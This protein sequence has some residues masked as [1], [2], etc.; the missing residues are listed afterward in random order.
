MKKKDTIEEM[1]RIIKVWDAEMN[2]AGMKPEEREGCFT[3]CLLLVEYPETPVYIEVLKQNGWIVPTQFVNEVFNKLENL[4]FEVTKE[5]KDKASEE[6][7]GSICPSCRKETMTDEREGGCFCNA[8][9]F[10]PCGFC[11]TLE[12]SCSCGFSINESF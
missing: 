8:T 5:D 10:P 7:E 12:L 3:E 4:A 1:F 11:T 6:G 2:N 9:N